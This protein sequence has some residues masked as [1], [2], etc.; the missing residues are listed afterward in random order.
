MVAFISKM[1]S[2]ISLNEITSSISKK[3]RMATKRYQLESS[4]NL[5]LIAGKMSFG[6]NLKN[7]GVTAFLRMKK[8][9][10]PAVNT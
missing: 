1:L 2:I 5:E 3:M 9:E 8:A 7:T 4:I 10:R 6:L